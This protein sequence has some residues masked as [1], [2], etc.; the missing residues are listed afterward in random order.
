M[1]SSFAGRGIPGPAG[2]AGNSANAFSYLLATSTAVPP[3]VGTAATDTATAESAA[4]IFLSYTDATGASIAPLLRDVTTGD[5]VTVQDKANGAS[6]AQYTVTGPAVDFP[7]DGYVSIP[8]VHTAGTVS[9]GKKNQAILVFVSRAGATGAQGATGT[10][11]T[12]GPQGP[13]GTTGTTGATGSQGPKGDPGVAGPQG[14]TGPQG[15]TGATGPQGPTG[16]TGPAGPATVAPGA[17]ALY[18]A[19]RYY[20]NRAAG[21]ASSNQSVTGGKLYMLPVWV[22]KATIIDRLAVGVFALVSGGTGRLGLYTVDDTLTGTLAVDAG[23]FTMDAAGYKELAMSYNVAAPGWLWF[24]LWISATTTIY[25]TASTY[26]A[27]GAPTAVLSPGSPFLSQASVSAAAGLPP[28]A[29]LAQ[30]G[31]GGATVPVCQYRMST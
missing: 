29:T 21:A 27:I 28:S 2:P 22:G 25:S 14:N 15:S 30:D 8:V 7:G 16:P 19:G 20:D 5:V 9:A 12:Q 26:M 1:R 3:A 6:F 13:Q 31:A 24:A 4:F 11:G 18:K 23:S 17:Y 10:T